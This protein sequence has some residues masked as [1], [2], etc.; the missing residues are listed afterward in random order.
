[1]TSLLTAA[2][3]V[4]LALA[5]DLA[6]QRVAVVLCDAS[7]RII[8]RIV[9]SASQRRRLDAAGAVV[10][11]DFSEQTIGTNRLGSVIE[12]QAPLFVHGA[13]H[14]SEALEEITCA[15]VPILDP[16]TRRVRGSLSLTSMASDSNPLMLTLTHAAVRDIE[17][18][19]LG[20]RD[21]GLHDLASAFALASRGQHGAIALLT[22]RTVLAN[23]AGLPY[24]SPANHAAIWD[25]L[26]SANIEQPQLLR[27]DLV[28]GAV[29]LRAQRVLVADEDLAFR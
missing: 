8:D 15:G 28:G 12:D 13:E 6:D 27:L 9:S 5:T 22:P 21:Q 26:V 14:F 7:G 11:S 29:N 3:P 2:R 18:R 24:V 19:L 25:S 10:G 20:G 4:I 16:R 23:T 1:M 17:T